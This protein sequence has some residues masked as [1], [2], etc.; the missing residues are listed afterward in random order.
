M[1]SYEHFP[2]V[3]CSEVTTFDLS[4]VMTSPHPF[5][6]F[7]SEVTWRGDVIHITMITAFLVERENNLFISPN[8]CQVLCV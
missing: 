6:I 1:G 5:V 7:L 3:V 4:S 2:F 8:L